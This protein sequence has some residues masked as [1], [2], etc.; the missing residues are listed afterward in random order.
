V[1]KVPSLTV[2]LPL[3]KKPRPNS[4]VPLVSGTLPVPVAAALT[5]VGAALEAVE[6][7]EDEAV[8]LVDDDA[9]GLADVGFSA[10]CTAA[11]SAVLTRSRAFWLAMLDRPV[12][13][14][15][16]AP[17]IWSMTA[18]LNDCA[19]VVCWDLA[20]KFWSCCQN[21]PL[22]TLIIEPA[23]PYETPSIDGVSGLI[24]G[25]Q[26]GKIHSRL[27]ILTDLAGSMSRFR[28]T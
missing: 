28:L 23:A 4:G 3:V 14:V 7:G 12:D 22:P 24:S 6:L 2:K 5:T 1:V 21:E 19:W 25:I 11:E 26:T 17:N 16:V 27:T 15:V 13:S 8:E 9:V 10:P 18:E 20:Q